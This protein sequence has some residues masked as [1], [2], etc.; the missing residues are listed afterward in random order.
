MALPN[1]QEELKRLTTPYSD[2]LFALDV[3]GE[4]PSDLVLLDKYPPGEIV[5]PAGRPREK[6][7][8]Y[9]I[10]SQ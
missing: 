7:W 10:R 4:S 9:R 6:L 5:G 2:R 3:L 1:S 8:L